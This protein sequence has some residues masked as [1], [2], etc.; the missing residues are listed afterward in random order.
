M[1]I[2]VLTGGILLGWKSG[3]VIGLL[4]PLLSSLATG[5]PPMMPPVAVAMMVELAMLGALAGALYHALKR[6]V[7]ATLA[8]AILAGR[9]AWGVTGWLL[10]PLLG[11][12]GLSILYPLGAGLV[13]SLP[14]IIVQ[15]VV[16]PVLVRVL[17]SVVKTESPR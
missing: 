13:T 8:V 9:L 4:T 7:F 6:N 3:L 10:L 5:M 1:H 12:R 11:I 16:V 2:P 17:G 14:G 15:F